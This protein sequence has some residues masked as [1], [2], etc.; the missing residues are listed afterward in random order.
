MHIIVGFAADGPTDILARLIGQWLSERLS[1]PFVIEDR[2]G[3]ATNIAT[4]AVAHAPPTRRAVRFI[5]AS[6]FQ[7]IL[8]ARFAIVSREQFGP[9]RTVFD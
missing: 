9:C 5:L 1:Q 3:A 2:P 4:E 7:C 8:A 6:K